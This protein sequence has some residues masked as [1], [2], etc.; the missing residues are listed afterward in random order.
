M[1]DLSTAGAGTDSGEQVSCK[2]SLL[3]EFIQYVLSVIV[4]G[5]IFLL[6][7]G[8]L[9][10][11]TEIA[12]ILD[13]N[14]VSGKTL[15]SVKKTTSEVFPLAVD[16]LGYFLIGGSILFLFFRTIKFFFELI[17]G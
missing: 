4:A 3:D 2:H 11:S 9:E 17:R 5:L 12:K 6:G 15:S 1:V 8:L 7:V 14:D 10:I 13:P 16:I